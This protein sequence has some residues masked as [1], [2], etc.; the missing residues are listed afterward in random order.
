[1]WTYSKLRLPSFSKPLTV[2]PLLGIEI[3]NNVYFF[4]SFFSLR[5][6]F[7]VVA[8]AG[9]QWR[10]LTATSAFWVQMILLLQASA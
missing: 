5:Y 9:V 1:M 7:A 3:Q 8:Q 4:L 10:D 2:G 6:S